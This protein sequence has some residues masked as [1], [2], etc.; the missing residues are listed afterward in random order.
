MT[1]SWPKYRYWLPAVVVLAFVAGCGGTA[2]DAETEIRQWL[3]EAEAEAEERD[4]RA[5]MERISTAYSDGRGN[6]YD[7]IGNMLRYVLLRQQRVS[8]LMNIEGIEVSAGTAAEVR[9][10]VAGAGMGGQAG[11]DADAYRFVLE[12]VRRDDEWLL[13]SA[14]WGRLGEDPR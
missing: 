4:R 9:L 6:D 10:T 1:Q 12:L 7:R 14:K 8:L 5:L 3:S 11:F 13:E 2:S